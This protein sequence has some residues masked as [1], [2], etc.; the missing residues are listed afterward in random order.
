[1]KQEKK[2]LDVRKGAAIFLIFLGIVMVIIL[3]ATSYGFFSYQRS[4]RQENIMY[5]ANLNIIV[6]DNGELGIRQEDSFP[7]YDEVGRKT[8]PY[9]FT[10]KNTGTVAAN[11]VMKLVPDEE[12]IEEDNCGNNLLQ[13]EAIKVQLIKDGEVVKEDYISNLNDYEIDSG[14][15][16]L[17]EGV[18]QSYDYELRLWIASTA[19]KEVM[20]RHYHGRVDVVIQDPANNS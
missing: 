13:E 18:N 2:A 12:A 1:M 5:T 14:F 7:V 9:R 17:V 20:G 6:D 15:I 8:E 11:Y 3:I 16:G 19:G 10:L 4:G